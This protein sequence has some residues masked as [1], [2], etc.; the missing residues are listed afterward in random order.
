MS[1][2]LAAKTSLAAR[3][4]AITDP[5]DVID[6]EFSEQNKAKLKWRVDR[7]NEGKANKISGQAK[8]SFNKPQVANRLVQCGQFISW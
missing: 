1:R 8:Y 3:V 7:W 6:V 5:E 4:D 2:M